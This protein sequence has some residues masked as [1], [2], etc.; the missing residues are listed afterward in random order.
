MSTQAGFPDP[1][2]LSN[3]DPEP[4]KPHTLGTGSGFCQVGVGVT[5]KQPEGDPC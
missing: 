5:L 4:E 2:D 3:P 1:T